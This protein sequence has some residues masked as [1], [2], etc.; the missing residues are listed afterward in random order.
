[1]SY[2]FII[3]SIDNKVVY[4]GV[5]S[6]VKVSDAQ[7]AGNLVLR[8]SPY[9]TGT[10]SV[11]VIS[12]NISGSGSEDDSLINNSIKAHLQHNFNILNIQD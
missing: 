6:Y 5:N 2:K 3:K 7:K 11:E 1:M 8:S 10:E 12:E 4:T 9:M